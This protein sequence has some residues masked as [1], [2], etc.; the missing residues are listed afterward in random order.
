VGKAI[1]ERRTGTDFLSVFGL[2]SDPRHSNVRVLATLPAYGANGEILFWTPLGELRDEGF[3][4]DQTGVETR[5][6]AENYPVFVFPKTTDPSLFTFT[7]VRQ[8]ALIDETQSTLAPTPIEGNPLGVRMIIFVNYSEKAFT[9]K[10]GILMME[11]MTK[12]NGLAADGTPLI[13]YKSD[14]EELADHECIT[15]Q[16]RSFWDDNPYTGIYSISPLIIEPTKQAIAA[17]AFLLMA[18]RDGAP[19]PS[20]SIFS[21]HFGCLQKY[22]EWCSE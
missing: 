17:D 1:I 7:N 22:G 15:M 9:T 5:Q 10:E 18:T 2:S 6:I 12:K 4:G 20:E 13:K 14:I 3:T 11:Y 8:A 19:L 16:K 21:H